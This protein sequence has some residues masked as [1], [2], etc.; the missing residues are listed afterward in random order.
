MT[1]DVWRSVK[2]SVE[3]METMLAGMVKLRHYMPTPEGLEALDATMKKAK[4]QLSE[5]RR[6]VVD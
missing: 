4:K 3:L 6:M 1:R 5:L 2:A